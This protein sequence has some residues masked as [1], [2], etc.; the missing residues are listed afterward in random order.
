MEFFFGEFAS[1]NVYFK[2]T[3]LH[4][5]L[6]ILRIFEERLFLRV[7]VDFCVLNELSTFEK[8]KMW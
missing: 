5:I 8:G 4:V 7:T 2:G 6:R 1:L 3:S